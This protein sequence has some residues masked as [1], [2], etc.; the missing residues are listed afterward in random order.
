MIKYTP[1]YNSNKKFPF[2]EGFIEMYD[3]D[4]WFS[5][6]NENEYWDVVCDNDSLF[7]QNYKRINFGKKEIIYGLISDINKI[8]EIPDLNSFWNFKNQL[9]ESVQSKI[10]KDIPEAREWLISVRD[11][12]QEKLDNLKYDKI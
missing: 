3:Q 4:F 7:D 10:F 5:Y 11:Y 8:L 1:I 9:W 12:M 2:F 6:A